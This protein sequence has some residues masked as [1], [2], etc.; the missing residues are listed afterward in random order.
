MKDVPN[1]RVRNAAIAGI[2]VGVLI[3]VSGLVTGRPGPVL[4]VAGAI[5]PAV[6]VAVVAYLLM[7][8]FT[9]RR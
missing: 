3:A 8:V 5:P 9:S 7:P 4:A 6:I 1:R 2:T